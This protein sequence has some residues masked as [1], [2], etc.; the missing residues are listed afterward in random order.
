MKMSWSA[1][2]QILCWTYLSLLC[3]ALAVTFSLHGLGI[4]HSYLSQ[5]FQNKSKH[6][7]TSPIVPEGKRLFKLL[8]RL[9][10]QQRAILGAPHHICWVVS[11]AR[12]G[13]TV[14]Y[15]SCLVTAAKEV[16]GAFK[17]AEIS[18]SGRLPLL[19]VGAIMTGIS[20]SKG[21]LPGWSGAQARWSRYCSCWYTHSSHRQWVLC[22]LMA[23]LFAQPSPQS[24]F[25]SG[26][27][28]GIFRNENVFIT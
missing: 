22:C 6:F 26:S 28:C 27:A 3:N 20:P 17:K 18:K 16:R 23:S 8:L 21:S 1:P 2:E 10:R 4:D 25:P 9:V 15:S 24:F 14:F 12:P 7:K 13:K 19:L 11:S 5:Y